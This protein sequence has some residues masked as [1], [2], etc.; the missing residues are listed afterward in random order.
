MEKSNYLEILIRVGSTRP[1]E[2]R[3]NAAISHRLQFAEEVA[4]Q[5][6]QEY[7]SKLRDEKRLVLVL[8]IDNTLLH[9]A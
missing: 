9:S 1:H 8:D 3:N 6:E 2:Y 4:Q 5:K 7:F